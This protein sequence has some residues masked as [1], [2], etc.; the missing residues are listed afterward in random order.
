MGRLQDRKVIVTGAADGIGLATV[1]LFLAEG[2]QVLAVDIS[3]SLAGVYAGQAGVTTS[4]LDV[5]DTDAAGK[6]IS[7]VK[8]M[9]GLD[10]LVNNAGICP[11]AL[12]SETDDSTWQKIFDVNVTSMFRISQQ[13]LPLL[14][15]ST[16]A[17]VINTASLSAVVANPMM[18]AYTASKHAV[19]GL[20]KN[21]A[22]EW[23]EFGITVNYILPGAIVTG[24]TRDI[25]AADQAFHDFWINK[26]ALKRLGQPEDIAKAMLFL[27]GDDAAFISGHG[28]VVDGGAL[29]S[30]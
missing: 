9:G 4:Q 29:I 14:K 7:A 22:L 30:A 10:I 2:A 5:T 21:M 26:A 6:I 12:L 20:S 17:R 19:A 23:G 28:L 15:Q 16:F 25:F 3:A 13:A 24:I 18:G 1:Q 27:A 11:P 8:Q